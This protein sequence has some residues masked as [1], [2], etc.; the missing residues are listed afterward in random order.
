MP[1][2][3]CLSQRQFG[4]CL[5]HWPKELS[6]ASEP[7]PTVGTTSITRHSVTEFPSFFITFLPLLTLAS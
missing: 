4:G 2:S 1:P 5:P 7:L 3:S 6:R